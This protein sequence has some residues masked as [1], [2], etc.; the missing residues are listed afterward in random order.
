M[1]QR[2]AGTATGC[3]MYAEG[4]ASGGGV[5][6]EETDDVGKPIGQQREV[7]AAEAATVVA[8]GGCHGL[9]GKEPDEEQVD[10]ILDGDGQHADD[11]EAQDFAPPLLIEMVCNAIH[12]HRLKVLC[13]H[14]CRHRR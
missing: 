12:L 4:V 3:R 6:E 14:G 8:L 2:E 9:V 5:V 7:L 11:A 13:R 10:A 1:G